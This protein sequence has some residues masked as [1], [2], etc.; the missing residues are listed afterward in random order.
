MIVRVVGI[1]TLL[2]ASFVA[3]C[4]GDKTDPGGGPTKPLPQVGFI[5]IDLSTGARAATVQIYVASTTSPQNW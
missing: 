1:A 2:L 3:G 4:A 5:T